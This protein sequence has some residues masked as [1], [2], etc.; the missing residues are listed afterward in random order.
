MDNTPASIIY[1]TM[2]LSTLTYCGILQLRLTNTQINR[3]SSFH[4]RS[5]KIFY[6]D[7][8]YGETAGEG[9]MQTGME[10]FFYF[11]GP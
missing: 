6:G 8:F 2:I 1:R 9:L 11:L 5:L 3:L 10:N 7:T 4:S